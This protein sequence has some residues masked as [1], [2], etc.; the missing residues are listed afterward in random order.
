[1]LGS[2]DFYGAAALVAAVGAIVS[3]VL[4]FL[5]RKPAATAAENSAKAA[6]A[7]EM[8]CNGGTIGQHVDKIAQAVNADATADTDPTATP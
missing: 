1:M 8:P 4:T 7:L 3:S 6:A 2:F 5:A